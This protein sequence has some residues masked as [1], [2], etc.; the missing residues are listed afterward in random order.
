[1]GG[2]QFTAIIECENDLFIAH[3][4]ELDI[5][6]CGVSSAAA[7][8]N[9]KETVA[10]FLANAQDAEILER[11]LRNVEVMPFDVDPRQTPAT[12]TANAARRYLDS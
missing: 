8:A 10:S 3:C 9:L 11:L 6:S 4:V 7:L 12:L 5:A 1:M 2:Y